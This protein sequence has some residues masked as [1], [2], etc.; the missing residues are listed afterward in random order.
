[1]FSRRTKR[2]TQL[3]NIIEHKQHYNFPTL[4]PCMLFVGT[5][6]TFSQDFSSS[7]LVEC[8][9]YH[10]FAHLPV[11]LLPLHL[12]SPL[13]CIIIIIPLA[14]TTFFRPIVIFSHT[15]TQQ[16]KESTGNNVQEERE[17][18]RERERKH[19]S[20]LSRILFLYSSA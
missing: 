3:K 18:E 19:F 14:A 10:N 8:V 7:H 2:S 13:A 15:H 1:M 6:L 11:V 12:F 4:I 20:R 5:V 16:G 17:R 9:I